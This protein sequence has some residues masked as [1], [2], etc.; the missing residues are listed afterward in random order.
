VRVVADTNVLLSAFCFPG[1]APELVYRLGLEGRLE[2]VTSTTLLAEFGRILTDKFGWE[3]DRAEEAVAQIT[4]VALVVDP[5][6][7]LDVITQDPA[8][9]RVLEAALASGADRI[10]SGDSHLLRLKTWR[11]VRVVAPAALLEE[12]E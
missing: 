6:E 7:R 8:D 1:G 5:T 4:R 3:I 11:D 2:L 10:V 9:D 12:F